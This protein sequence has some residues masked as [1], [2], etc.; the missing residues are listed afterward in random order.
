MTY[1]KLLIILSIVSSQI[2]N[3]LFLIVP[4]ITTIIVLSFLASTGLLIVI[5]SFAQQDNQTQQGPLEQLEQ[6]EQLDNQTS[7]MTTAANQTNQTG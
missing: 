3:N 2:A 4:C 1:H 6:L 5:S 7:S